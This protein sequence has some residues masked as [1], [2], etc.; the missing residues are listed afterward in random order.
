MSITANKSYYA[1]VN[2]NSCT[3][4]AA[5]DLDGT[6]IDTKSGCKFP[7]NGQDWKFKYPTV[8]KNLIEY[9]KHDFAI[10]FITNQKPLG[11]SNDKL[12]EF[13][14]KINDIIKLIG[15][16]VSYFIS[17][18]SDRFRKPMT[19]LFELMK[20]KL[21][22]HDQKSFLKLEYSFYCG[23]AAGRPKMWAYKKIGNTKTQYKISKDFSDSDE[24]FASNCGLPFIYPEQIFN[25][26]EKVLTN[27]YPLPKNHLKFFEDYKMNEMFGTIKTIKHFANYCS[28]SPVIIILIGLPASGKT[29]LV[30]NILKEK[31]RDFRVLSKDKINSLKKYNAVLRECIN[32][33]EDIIIDNTNTKREDRKLLTSMAGLEYISIGVEIVAHQALI[34]HL[35]IYRANYGNRKPI[36]QIVY[37]IMKK[38]LKETPVSPAEFTYCFKIV[39]QINEK[40]MDPE[41]Y[42]RLVSFRP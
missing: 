14:D 27:T 41:E 17:I 20:D 23:D 21:F 3:K 32:K 34:H 40:N 1:C 42:K 10:V 38:Q 35:N 13:V 24:A 28:D 36:P 6:I 9:H 37:N 11:K 19:G 30:K 22:T 29:Y 18:G 33:K 26:L 39:N 5:F 2:E 7:R 12:M 15:V 25:G 4:V 31:I 16:P 8:V